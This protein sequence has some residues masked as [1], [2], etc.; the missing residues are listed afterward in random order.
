[1]L[2]TKDLNEPWFSLTKIKKKKVEG[3]LNKGSFAEM[4]KGDIIE[5]TNNQLGYQRK[6]RVKIKKITKYN[7]FEEYLDQEKLK[8]CLPG[9][10]TI[11]EGVDIYHNIYSPED[12]QKYKVLAFQI[13]KLSQS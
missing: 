8:Y 2:Y 5:F 1:M 12:E 3:R 6:F 13:K 7:S 9:I 4:N 10:D 11:K